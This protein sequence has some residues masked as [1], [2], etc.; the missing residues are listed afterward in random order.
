MKTFREAFIRRYGNRRVE[1]VRVLDPETGIGLE[2]SVEG[3]WTDPVPWIDDLEW[4]RPAP[5]GVAVENRANP[6]LGA[7]LFELVRNQQLYLTLESSDL[8]HLGIHE[9]SWPAQMTALVELFGAAGGA[10]ADIHIVHGSSGN[11]AFLLGRFGFADPGITRQWIGQLIEDE[12]TEFPDVIFAEVVHLPEDRTG[13]VLQ[14]PAF[15]AYEIPYLARS[16]KDLSCQIPVTDLLISV[17][18]QKVVLWSASREKRVR[19]CMTNAYNHQLG[20]LAVYKFLHR[21]RFE[22]AEMDYKPDWGNAL[23]DAPFIPG[24]RFKNMVLS[25]PVWLVTCEDI[26]GWIHAETNESDLAALAEWRSERQMPEEMLWMESDQELY[27]NWTNHNLVMALW[28]VIKSRKQARFRPFFFTGTT[29][30][31]SP[32]GYHANQFVFCFKKS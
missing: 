2:G 16:P 26:A 19:P 30:V 10:D 13:N 31:E 21:I 6:W 14:R 11:P 4:G 3:Y 32:A 7:R 25:S 9:G 15:L 8:Q 20:S 28:D 23:N 24:I 17:E 12:C 1:L 22:E 18:N 27:V 5:A 29:P